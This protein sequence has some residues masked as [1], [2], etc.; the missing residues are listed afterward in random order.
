MLI[1]R[2]A[3]QQ[4]ARSAVGKSLRRLLDGLGRHAAG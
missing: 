2:A 1:A 3:D 4:R